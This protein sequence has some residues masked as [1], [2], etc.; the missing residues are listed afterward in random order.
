MRR[1][2]VFV[3]LFV[4]VTLLSGGV[5]AQTTMEL[6]RPDML[7]DGTWYSVRRDYRKCMA[8]MCGGYWVKAMNQRKTQCVDG[9]RA[10]EIVLGHPTFLVG[11]SAQRPLAR[12]P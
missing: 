8:P 6:L 2:F 7:E 11:R 12:K 5:F 10:E 4:R 3:S 9:T 1:I